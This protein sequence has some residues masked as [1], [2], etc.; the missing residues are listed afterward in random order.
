MTAVHH[1]GRAGRGSTV[2]LRA[3]S[4]PESTM[5]T[6]TAS[7]AEPPAGPT[8]DHR[9]PAA[10]FHEGELEVQRLTGVTDEA[11][12]LSGMLAPGQ[13]DG[14]IGRFLPDRTF[15]VL[16]GRDRD[17]RLWTSALVG[18]PGFLEPLG[19]TTLLVRTSP[20]AGDPLHG[21]PSGQPVGIVVVEFA[22]RR[23]VRI[24][25]T[26]AAVT[27]NTLRIAV[28]Q[29]YGN[30]PQYIQQRTIS[31]V[32]DPGRGTNRA[33]RRNEL[34]VD[35]R[36]MIRA[37]DTFFIGTLHPTRGADSSHRG[38]PVGF[39]RIDS[40]R[41][42]WPDYAGNNMF[43]TLGNL[44]VD[45]S[46]ALLFTDFATGHTLQLSGTAALDQTSRNVPGD[47]GGTGRRVCFTPESMVAAQMDSLHGDGA[48]AYA[49]N[50]PITD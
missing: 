41:L 18:P 9:R 2:L 27:E 46:A 14:G 43:N 1:P 31:A 38:G 30:C 44:A 35:D 45:P 39:V 11:A 25:G 15:A 7:T 16:T 50:P 8:A 12:R 10:G 42:W 34:T 36:A 33:E 20:A 13:L 21:L 47:D 26:L 28:D 4:A 24:N 3:I 19:A 37:A 22:T 5:A 40:G 32:P 6:A 29:A 17:G 23:R 48:V 49:R